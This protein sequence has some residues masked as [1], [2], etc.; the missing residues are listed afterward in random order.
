MLIKVRLTCLNKGSATKYLLCGNWEAS[1]G[2]QEGIWVMTKCQPKSKWMSSI[3]IPV[4][5]WLA[6][7]VLPYLSHRKVT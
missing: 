3:Q 7:H 1:I 2:R 6:S 5:V 4:F